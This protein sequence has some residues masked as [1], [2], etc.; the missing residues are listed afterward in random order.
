MTSEKTSRRLLDRTPLFYTFSHGLIGKNA[1]KLSAAN[2]KT[3]FWEDK[4]MTD[5]TNNGCSCTPNTS[6]RCAVTNCANHCKDAQYCGL[7]AIQV[8]TH[9]AN[10]TMDQCTDCQSFKKQ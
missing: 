3:I 6:I 1:R 4:S 10:P 9:E 8:G 5:H 2:A 7:N